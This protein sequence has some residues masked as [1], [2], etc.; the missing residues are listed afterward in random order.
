MLFFGLSLQS[1]DAMYL[2]FFRV[3]SVESDHKKWVNTLYSL[4]AKLTPY[5]D[6]PFPNNINFFLMAALHCIKALHYPIHCPKGGAI[7]R[8]LLKGKAVPVT[9]RE[10]P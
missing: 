8:S 4:D 9:G 1:F 2:N 3:S 6:W 7:G 10:G 5:Q